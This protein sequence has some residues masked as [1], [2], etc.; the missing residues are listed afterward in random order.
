MLT[1]II[2]QVTMRPYKLSDYTDELAR[3]HGLYGITY[4]ELSVANLNNIF[5][6]IMSTEVTPAAGKLT[7]SSA[8][9][10]GAGQSD[11]ADGSGET[12]ESGT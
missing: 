11:P 6:N 4:D 9:A 3:K 7:V 5:N 12:S 1:G 2:I 10:A 8:A